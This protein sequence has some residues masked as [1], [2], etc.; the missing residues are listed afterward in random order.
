MTKASSVFFFCEDVHKSY[1]IEG[2]VLEQYPGNVRKTQHEHSKCE[3]IVLIEK[4]IE[5]TY[6]YLCICIY[7]YIYICISIYSHKDWKTFDSMQ[8]RHHI[9]PS[10]FVEVSTNPVSCTFAMPSY[11]TISCTYVIWGV[12]CFLGAGFFL[13]IN[14]KIPILVSHKGSATSPHISSPRPK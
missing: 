1:V 4:D 12:V 3:N 11:R 8:K 7:L 10:M 5:C 6:I 14:P 2:A 9:N 13:K